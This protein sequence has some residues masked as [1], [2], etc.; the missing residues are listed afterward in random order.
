MALT[1]ILVALTFSVPGSRD[2]VEVQPQLCGRYALAL[3]TDFL[4]ADTP[5]DALDRSLPAEVAPFSLLDLETAAREVGLDTLLLQLSEPLAADLECPCIL[6]IKVTEY[7]D[8]PNH[9]VACSAW[10]LQVSW[11]APDWLSMSWDDQPDKQVLRIVM[12]SVTA[13][14][15]AKGFSIPLNSPQG[16]SVEL[17]VQFG[18]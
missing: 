6:H 2:E 17:P 11:R 4:N 9:F 7:S 18:E 13:P 3:V 15:S 16:R 8:E 5:W 14:A 12:R 1:I 10:G